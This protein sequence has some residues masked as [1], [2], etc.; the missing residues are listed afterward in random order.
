M[1]LTWPVEY[2]EDPPGCSAYSDL[3]DEQIAS[4]EQMAVE[5]L[6]RWTGHRLGTMEVVVRPCLEAGRVGTWHSPFQRGVP[7]PT[8][9]TDA[10]SGEYEITTVTTRCGCLGACG[11]SDSSATVRLPGP[12]AE[13]LS[14]QVGTDVV[15]PEAYRVDNRQ[16]LVRQDGYSWPLV[17][18]LHAPLGEPDTWAVAY[19]MG[20]PVPHGGQLAAG[21]LACELAKQAANDASCR[22]PKRFQAI[23]RQGVT[24]SALDTFEDVEKGRTGIWMIDSWVSSMMRAP[25]RSTVRSPDVPVMR[26]QTWP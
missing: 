13:V 17:Q 10:V 4:Y 26:R 21:I 14:V 24:V 22:L 8:R 1:T 16:I 18:N 23:T 15:P 7:V 12:I 25:T 3:T 9:T 2:A 19:V 20:T 6:W 11:C 5:F